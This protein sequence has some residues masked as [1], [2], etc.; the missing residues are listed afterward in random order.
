MWGSGLLVPEQGGRRGPGLH[1]IRSA[2]EMQCWCTAGGGPLTPSHYLGVW[3]GFG[4]GSRQHEPACIKLNLAKQGE[5][6]SR[7]LPG[8]VDSLTHVD[9]VRCVPGKRADV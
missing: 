3:S 5:A 9:A 8:L 7:V 4:A 1:R 6:Q 2:G